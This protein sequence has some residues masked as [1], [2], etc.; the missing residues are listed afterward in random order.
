[1][2]LREHPLASLSSSA[3]GLARERE[4]GSSAFAFEPRTFPLGRHRLSDERH[5]NLAIQ[6]SKSES[7]T[8]YS[9]YENE[10]GGCARMD[11]F[12]SWTK[13]SRMVEARY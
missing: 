4:G 13:N 11:S 8:T 12:R 9:R 3:S 2:F 6:K 1:M 7:D 10:K 5:R